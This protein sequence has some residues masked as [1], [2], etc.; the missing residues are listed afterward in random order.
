MRSGSCWLIENL[1]SWPLAQSLQGVCHKYCKIAP[2]G[3]SGCKCV[4]AFLR[5]EPSKLRCPGKDFVW[6]MPAP[7]WEGRQGVEA[8]LE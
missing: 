7:A 1:T 6:S 2:V 8:A 4:F 3:T 5:R